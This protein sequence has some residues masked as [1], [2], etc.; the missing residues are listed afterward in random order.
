[1]KLLQI[2]MLNGRHETTAPWYKRAVYP[3]D[4]GF[5]SVDGYLITTKLELV[6]DA[7][8]ESEFSDLRGAL[9]AQYPINNWA[10][11][12]PGVGLPDA[13]LFW[14]SMCDKVVLLDKTMVVAFFIRID[15]AGM[16]PQSRFA[17]WHVLFDAPK[18]QGHDKALASMLAETERDLGASPVWAPEDD[19]RLG[20]LLS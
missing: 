19:G 5:W 16:S 9:K 7:A 6:F 17:A 20:R 12:V 15:M 4:M 2:A 10:L 1:M 3:A 14:G 18:R 13:P 11:H 8:P